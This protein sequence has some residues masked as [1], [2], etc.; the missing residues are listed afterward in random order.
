MRGVIAVLLAALAGVLP[1]AAAR[2]AIP[3]W[4]P[5]SPYGVHSMLYLDAPLAFQEALFREAAAMRAAWIRL[6]VAVPDIVRTP[7]ARD[8][9]ALDSDLALARRYGLRVSAVL[10][11]TPWWLARCPPRT[12]LRDTYR[13]PP[14]DAARWAA[15]V[16][17]IA[18]HARGQVGAWEILNEPDQRWAFRGG[19]RDYAAVL[20]AAHDAI[21]RADPAATVVLGGLGGLGSRPWLARVLA[22]AGRPPGRAFD[23]AGVHVRGRLAKL[24]VKL[25]DWRSFLARHGFTGPLWVTEHGYPSQRRWQFDPRFR[26]GEAAQA[27]Y[28]SRSVPALLRAG[29]ANVFVTERDNLHGRFSSEGLLGGE[30]TDPPSAAPHV[31]PKLAVGALARLAGLPLSAATGPGAPCAFVAP[32]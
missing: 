6:D 30:V 10:V 4:P 2:A 12:E 1:P 18:A 17:E 9:R 19:A 7:R 14:R 28:L 27:D 16:Q 31:V 15:Y 26:G 25:G 11:G 3:P 23:V 32:C 21:K 8:W 20:V 24:P 5:A 13:C 22:A 29:A